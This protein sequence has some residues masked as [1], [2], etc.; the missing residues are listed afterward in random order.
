MSKHLMF[1]LLMLIGV[2]SAHAIFQ[3]DIRVADLDAVDCWNPA[4]CTATEGWIHLYNLDGP[5]EYIVP[6]VINQGGIP[7]AFNFQCDGDGLFDCENPDL[8]YGID[9]V[10]AKFEGPGFLYEVNN[11]NNRSYECGPAFPIRIIPPAGDGC[12]TPPIPSPWDLEHYP[13][14]QI[15]L[16]EDYTVQAD[17]TLVIGPGME[18]YG[19]PGV[20]LTVD[21]ELDAAGTDEAWI[22][23]TGENWDGLV[24]NNDC[25]ATFDHCVIRDVDSPDD[26]GAMTVNGGALVHLFNSLVVHNSTTGMGGAAYIADQ[27]LLS[28]NR[29]TV[30]HNTGGTNGGIYLAGGTAFL[31]SVM[32]LIT[33]SEPTLTDVTGTGLTNVVFTNIFPQSENFP[34][35]MAIPVW[36]C[37][38][39]YVDAANFDF[40]ISYWSLTNPDEVNCII[41]VSVNELENDPD[42]TP[43]DMGAFYF[44]QHAILNPAAIVAV[45]DRANDQGGYVIIEFAAS[46][47]DGSWLNPVTLYSVWERYPGMGEDEWVSAGTVAALADPDM[48]YF[49][50]VPTLNDQFEGNENIHTFMIGTHSVQF[51]VPIPSATAQGFSLDNIAPAALAS[52]DASG[53][54]YETPGFDNLDISWAGS[55][56]NDLNGYELV[57]SLINDINTASLVPD[58]DGQSTAT[59]FTSPISDL[60]VGDRVHFW[61]LA[62]DVHENSSPAAYTFSDFTTDVRVQLPTAYEL[63]Q[64]FP[65]PFNPTTSI[66]F[67]LPVGGQ[68][69]LSVY[70]MLGAKVATL[71]NGNR[72]AGRYTASFDGRSLASGVYF[73]KLEAP[74]FS[75]LK[76]MILVK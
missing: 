26:G 18:I 9:H 39:G 69:N 50:Q 28:L 40:H 70:N 11:L 71:V 13:S 75:D 48:H 59:T 25:D 43:G 27:G 6:A 12:F 3:F 42:G 54:W 67:S 45:A 51:P 74:N 63:G 22:T 76:K 46:P 15:A 7:L 73:Y 68:V 30:S 17:S 24:F 31:E 4:S 23:F 62:Q 58:Y 5:E 66:N 14:G 37:D 32:S 21:G 19:L 20:S 47:N 2:N 53:G 29:C 56:A 57:Y 8:F 10:Y 55:N 33:Y 72:P 65:N 49:V 16:V 41:D 38:P 1:G 60:E 44:D 34:P 52:F 64:N 61:V 36:Y 35:G